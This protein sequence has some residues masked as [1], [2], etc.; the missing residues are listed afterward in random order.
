MRRFFALSMIAILSLTLALAALSCGKKQEETTTTT[1]PAES[2]MPADT[3]MSNM[4]ADTSM[5]HMAADT[6]KK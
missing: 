6:T 3:G 2:S 4:A 1:P 5:G